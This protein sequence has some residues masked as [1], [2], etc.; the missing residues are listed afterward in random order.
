[1]LINKNTDIFTE[2]DS[3]IFSENALDPM[4]T[5]LIWITLG[6]RIFKSRLNTISTDIRLYT[7]NLFHH[8]VIYQCKKKY[9]D[10]FINI[11]CRPPYNNIEDLYDGII[12]FLECLLIHSIDQINENLPP[13]KQITVPGILKLKN[14]RGRNNLDSRITKIAADK[15]GGILAR[16]ILLGIHGRHKGPFQEM[17]IF[18]KSAYYSNEAI[19]K[20]AEK[21]FERKPWTELKIMLTEKIYTHI[22]TIK[23]GSETVKKFRVQDILSTDVVKK[24]RAVMEGE[25]FK[26]LAAF[27]ENRLGLNCGTAGI[28]YQQIKQSKGG[29]DYER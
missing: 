20:E 16:Q 17:G 1:M 10:L 5:R 27:W 25:T 13:E 8:S 11:S 14:L 6:N 12:I 22:L 28:L 9:E 29:Y 3:S 18:E 15:T 23:I 19:W 7:L 26:E 2:V 21:F 4:G 24:Y